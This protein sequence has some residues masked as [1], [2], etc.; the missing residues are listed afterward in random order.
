MTTACVG[1][2]GD[3]SQTIIVQDRNG[4]VATSLNQKE[5]ELI[6]RVR[7][8]GE[9]ASAAEKPSEIIDR[10]TTTLSV[11]EYQ[12]RY[13][14]NSGPGE[15]S[16]TVGPNDVLK[17]EIFDEKELSREAVRVSG[18]G[19]ISFPLIGRVRVDGFTTNAIERFIAWKMKEGGFLLDAQVSALIT[20]F[21]SKRYKVLGAVKKPG[22]FFLKS[23]EQILDALSGVEGVD[24]ETAGKELLVLRQQPGSRPGDSTKIVISVELER[25]LEGGDTQSNLRLMPDDVVY[26]P[27]AAMF[28][29]MGE[30]KVPGSYKFTK[31]DITLVEAISTAGGFTPIAARNRT[32]IVRV[33]DGREKIITV[34]VDAITAAGR[35]IDDVRIKPNDIVIVPES[36][37]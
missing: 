16:Y 30:V 18:D 14:T 15:L 13:S 34:N 4:T 25:L 23:S 7:E 21:G 24:Q 8:M 36:F 19:Y 28:Y 10:K 1:S 29:I 12:K 26:V 11:E 27:K 20:E 33:D 37:F 22:I 3:V 9:F 17:I 6:E 32:R 2:G 5:R 35:K 31:K